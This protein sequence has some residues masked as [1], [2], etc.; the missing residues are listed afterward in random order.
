MEGLARLH[1]LDTDAVGLGTLGRGT[2]YLPRQITAWQRMG[3]QYRTEPFGQADAVRDRLLADAPEQ[4]HITLVHGDYRL[5]NTLIGDDGSLNAILDWELCTRGDPYV[6][7]AVCLYYWTEAGDPLH[8]FRDPPTVMDGFMRREDL[9]VAYVAAGGRRPP[10]LGYY[11]GYA[12]WR[13]ALVLEGVLGRFV[14]GAYGDSDPAEE[15]RLA[16]TVKALIAHAHALLDAAEYDRG[17]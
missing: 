2:E 11:L 3:D 12:A 9:L 17:R 1:A 7:L 13:L 14:S 15:E 10:R 4:E 8:P 16:R 6:D 5:D